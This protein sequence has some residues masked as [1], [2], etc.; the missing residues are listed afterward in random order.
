MEGYILTIGLENLGY[1]VEIELVTN[2]WHFC[3]T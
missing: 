1:A 2:R 3:A